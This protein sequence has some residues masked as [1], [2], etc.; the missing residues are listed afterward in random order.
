M[1][2]LLGHRQ[3]NLSVH[4]ITDHTVWY[5]CYTKIYTIKDKGIDS[6][7]IVLGV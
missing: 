4:Y 2:E 5:S 3:L 6:A 1:L 7:V